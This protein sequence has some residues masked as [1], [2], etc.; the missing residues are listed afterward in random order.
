MNSN[1][2]YTF[3]KQGQKKTQTFM[4]SDAVFKKLPHYPQTGLLTVPCLPDSHFIH[5]LIQ[6]TPSCELNVI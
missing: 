1:A 2:G 3:S 5:L 6:I 4:S